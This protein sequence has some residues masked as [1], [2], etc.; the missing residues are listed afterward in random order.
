MA[1]VRPIPGHLEILADA[2]GE[3]ARFQLRDG[4]VLWLGQPQVQAGRRVVALRCGDAE[5]ELDVS[6][7]S[8]PQQLYAFLQG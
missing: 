2:D 4:R 5:T 3:L 1:I 6:L 7:E 8:W